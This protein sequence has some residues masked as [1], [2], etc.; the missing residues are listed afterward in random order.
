M[1]RGKCFGSEDLVEVKWVDGKVVCVRVSDQ[2]TPNKDEG[3]FSLQSGSSLLI[4]RYR[5]AG[6]N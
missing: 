5:P 3:A 6:G 1:N 2:W 4:G